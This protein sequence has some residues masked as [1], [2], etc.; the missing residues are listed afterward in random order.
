[1][2]LAPRV[3][4]R[5]LDFGC[6]YGFDADTFGWESYDPFYRPGQPAGPFDTIVCVGVANALSRNNRS[7]VISEIQELLAEDG[8]AYLAVPRNLPVEGK[9][10]INHSLQNYVVL[11]LP[12]I[13]ESDEF[14]IYELRK[15]DRPR[16]KT[17]EY[18][19]PRDRRSMRS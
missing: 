8:V 2:L 10:G 11:T 3:R 16:D 9:L 13:H 1:M 7:A 14:A 18:M 5:V 15:R 6:G 17:V 4:G 19:T 12:L